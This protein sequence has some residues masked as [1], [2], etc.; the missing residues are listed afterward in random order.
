MTTLPAPLPLA[1][2]DFLIILAIQD[3]MADTTIGHLPALVTGRPGAGGNRLRWD[4]FDEP[5]SRWTSV[6]G[7]DGWVYNRGGTLGDI[8]I[9]AGCEV[10]SA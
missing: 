4:V 6:C 2:A 8:E 3:G 10:A 5:P 9:C 1:P 7:V